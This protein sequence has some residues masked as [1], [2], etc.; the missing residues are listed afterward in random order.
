MLL[1]IPTQRALAAG[2]VLLGTAE[3]GIRVCPDSWLAPGVSPVALR[4]QLREL[5]LDL[6]IE[7]LLLA[8]GEPVRENAHDALD[9]GAYSVTSSPASAER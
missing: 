4:E 8:H 5:L 2:D 9:S 1:W 3:G 7:L 6:P